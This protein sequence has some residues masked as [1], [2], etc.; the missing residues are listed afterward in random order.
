MQLAKREQIQDR[1]GVLPGGLAAEIQQAD[2]LQ[3]DIAVVRDRE[4]HAEIVAHDDVIIPFLDA[5][6]GRLD[7]AAV[8]DLHH[9][10]GPAGLAQGSVLFQQRLPGRDL[11]I[12]CHS[13]HPFYRYWLP[14]AGR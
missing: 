4:R 13:D 9:F 10:S 6:R 12:S 2:G 3:A 14:V 5:E 8:I 1:L 11:V 7:R